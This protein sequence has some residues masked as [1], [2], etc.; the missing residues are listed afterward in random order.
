MPDPEPHQSPQLLLACRSGHVK[1]VT[2][3]AVS[4]DASQ[5]PR[6]SAVAEFGQRHPVIG[7][8]SSPDCGGPARVYAA[9]ATGLL[10][11]LDDDLRQMDSAEKAAAVE[12][13]SPAEVPAA[14]TT[15]LTFCCS[16]ADSSGERRDLLAVGHE[17]GTVRLASFA[18]SAASCTDA[19]QLR[20]GCH[21]G[22]VRAWGDSD[23]RL[24][25][26]GRESDLRV[27]DVAAESCV[28]QAKNLPN[29]RLNLRR[30]VDVRDIRPIAGGQLLAVCTGHRELR[31]Y[32]PGEQ[33]RPVV[34]LAW[35][36]YPI[37]S[38][39]AIEAASAAA[40]AA[41]NSAGHLGLF[42]L[43]RP[44]AASSKSPAAAAAQLLGHFKPSCSGAVTALD[45]VID[46]GLLFAT[47]EDRHLRVFDLR[48]R[49]LL[50]QLYAKSRLAGLLPLSG[51]SE[52]TRSS[53][54]AAGDRVVKGLTASSS[55]GVSKR[56]LT[57]QLYLATPA[58]EGGAEAKAAKIDK[59]KAGAAPA[60]GRG[61]IKFSFTADILAHPLKNVTAKR[62]AAK[63][64][65]GTAGRPAAVVK[66]VA[67]A[68][69]AIAAPGRGA[70]RGLAKRRRTLGA[71]LGRRFKKGGLLD[72]RLGATGSDGNA[73]VADAAAEVALRRFAAQKRRVLAAE[74]EAAMRQPS[75]TEDSGLLSAVNKF[76]PLAT[77]LDDAEFDDDD[78][79]GA[80][81]SRLSSEA[82]FDEGGLL[83]KG[84]GLKDRMETLIAQ[85]RADRAEKR[86]QLE[87]TRRLTDAIDAEWKSRV[88]FQLGPLMSVPT[89]T[90][91]AP[92][93]GDQLSAF[94]L[95]S[96]QLMQSQRLVAKD[97]APTG[98][99]G[100]VAKAKLKPSERRSA[101]EQLAG[102]C[103]KLDR[104]RRARRQRVA[105]AEDGHSASGALA[106]PP[107]PY[108]ETVRLILR[109]CNL[110]GF[111]ARRFCCLRL[112][113]AFCAEVLADCCV[114]RRPTGLKEI[115]R[116]LLLV[117]AL[118]R[119]LSALHWPLCP[120]LLACLHSLLLIAS[121]A[122][123]SR[124]DGGGAPHANS[125]AEEEQEEDSGASSALRR[126]QQLLLAT[127]PVPADWRPGPLPLSLCQ[128]ASGLA[129]S[130]AAGLRLLCLGRVF[131][132]LGELLTA[133]RGV[134]ATGGLP[135]AGLRAA[136]L[137]LAEAAERAK[138]AAGGGLWPAEI[139][140]AADSFLNSFADC[141]AEATGARLL[142]E[143]EPPRMLEL[144]EPQVEANFDPGRRKSDSSSGEE[145]KR[146]LRARKRAMKA[147]VRE[148]ARDRDFLAGERLETTLRADAQ[149]KRK[150]R[151]LMGALGNQE[152]EVKKLSRGKK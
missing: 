77:E 88:R 48:G 144:L 131:A 53:V 55:E 2:F 148:V 4:G 149:R 130:Q 105:A 129:S 16:S 72:R 24:A 128:R 96:D 21:V 70:A 146:L 68:A 71:E 26:G 58:V 138:A 11:R 86:E 92:E 12:M 44:P 126:R 134:G 38:C 51:V 112:G 141:S 80:G 18:A 111:K 65:N 15:C 140:N 84:T 63:A 13:T 17:D 42:D 57:D 132:D 83:R 73:D 106:A 7:L 135:S 114:R 81:R 85:T 30:P 3:S 145:R 60:A 62:S 20:A 87:E 122:D 104:L 95:L 39:C 10:R 29:D 117:S 143:R 89:S 1:S 54:R 119:L 79:S 101:G 37:Q 115:C 8:A 46:A 27:W 78:A 25:T 69:K 98:N 43:R 127:R 23:A 97:A 6:L 22:V 124:W 74:A 107:A 19:A 142:R 102:L 40:V 90:K 50:C 64:S 120:E 76:A 147:A 113:V 109:L 93:S 28:F 123:A 35:S 61:P 121:P 125:D 75:E 91:A 94:K 139:L 137:P 118:K 5:P 150:V 9:T 67:K 110:S 136:F 56:R 103:S 151:E 32:S 108:L 14:A 31:L 36:E 33:R 47:S 45:A 52:L 100:S 41:G 66:G 59:K 116:I 49:R 99:G 82:L 34:N 152:G 133:W